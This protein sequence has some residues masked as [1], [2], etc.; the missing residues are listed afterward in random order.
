MAAIYRAMIRRADKLV[1]AK[2]QPFW[3]HPAG[4]Q[5]SWRRGGQ[6]QVLLFF[7]FNYTPMFRPFMLFFIR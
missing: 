1:P 2:F 3:N 7:F 6:K 5:T 4:K